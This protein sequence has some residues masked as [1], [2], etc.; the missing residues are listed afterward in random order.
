MAG[1]TVNAYKKRAR[2]SW[3][4]GKGYKGDSSER[5]YAKEEV[6]HLLEEMDEGYIAP[7]KKSERK[8]NMRAR[9]EHR[10]KWCEGIIADYKRN[11]HSDWISSWVRDHLARS[12]KELEELSE[13][14]N[15]R[16]K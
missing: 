11:G 8:R 13:T 2:G 9:L 12:K 14:K 5:M 7:Y 15:C 6:R 4:Q 10:I 16:D 1:G 3:R